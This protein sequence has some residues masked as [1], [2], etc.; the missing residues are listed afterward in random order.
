MRTGLNVAL[1]RAQS[2]AIVVGS[3]QWV[4]TRVATIRRMKLGELVLPDSGGGAV[5][6]IGGF[7]C[8][9]S[10]RPPAGGSRVAATSFTRQF[11]WLG[12]AFD[13]QDNL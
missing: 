11:W 7:G 3:P 9:R 8:S 4:H 2:L 6:P 1:S 10:N 13:R 12:I 5:R